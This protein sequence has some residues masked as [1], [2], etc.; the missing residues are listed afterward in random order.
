MNISPLPGHSLRHPSCQTNRAQ[1]CPSHPLKTARD[2]IARDSLQN[3]HILTSDTRLPDAIRASSS[4][5]D[6]E[7]KQRRGMVKH[8]ASLYG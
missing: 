6:N 3:R 1:D 5:L 8:L 4:L 2:S 7:K